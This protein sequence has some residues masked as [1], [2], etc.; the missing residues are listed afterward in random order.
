MYECRVATCDTG[1]KRAAC[2][3]ALSRSLIIDVDAADT[4]CVNI[5]V[6]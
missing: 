2:V 3:C 5:A 1:A 6:C 4:V